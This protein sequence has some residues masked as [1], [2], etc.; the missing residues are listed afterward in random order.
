MDAEAIFILKLIGTQR[1]T[2]ID[3]SQLAL[4]GKL[5]MLCKRQHLPREGE[6]CQIGGLGRQAQVLKVVHLDATILYKGNRQPV[7]VVVILELKQST[8]PELEL[9]L[10]GVWSKVSDEF[11]HFE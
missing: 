2:T 4:L 6:Y 8:K 7:A 10:S 3:T 9:F 11:A 1:P 5:E